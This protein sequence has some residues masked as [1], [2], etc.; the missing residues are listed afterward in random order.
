MGLPHPFSGKV[1]VQPSEMGV[2]TPPPRSPEQF[3]EHDV[4]VNF[5]VVRVPSGQPIS[6][7][8]FLGL[9]QDILAFS[10]DTGGGGGM[11]LFH[12]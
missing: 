10:A 6:N 7:E 2:L 5:E 1:A 4:Q 12:I 11:D 8:P 9:D 3:Q